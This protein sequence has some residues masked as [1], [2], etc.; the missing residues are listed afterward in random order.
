MDM[1]I[2]S[3]YRIDRQV[4]VEV[5]TP[6]HLSS[7]FFFMVR[8]MT[9]RLVLALVE[10]RTTSHNPRSS[11]FHINSMSLSKV[12]VKVYLPAHNEQLVISTY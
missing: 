2:S 11:S 9:N 6:L 12:K 3:F 10:T 8:I 1:W 5:E 4:E 7:C